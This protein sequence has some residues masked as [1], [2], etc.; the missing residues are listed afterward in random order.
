MTA[1]SPEALRAANRRGVLAITAG[2]ACFVTNDSLVK[3]VSESLPASQLIFVRGLMST[4]LLVAIVFAMGAEK[5][6]R[7]LG[8]KRV[9]LRALMDAFGTL[10]YLSSLFQIP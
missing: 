7:D 5:R 4:A 2:M 3:Y 1:S 10:V 6:W 9:V 8:D